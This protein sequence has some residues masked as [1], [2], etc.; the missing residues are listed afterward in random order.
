LE[1]LWLLNFLEETRAGLNSEVRGLTVCLQLVGHF[2]FG[3]EV[4]EVGLQGLTMVKI[5]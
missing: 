2:W 4:G 5:K 3:S 1:V